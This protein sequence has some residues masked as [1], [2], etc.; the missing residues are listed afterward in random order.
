[1][2]I[3]ESQY[4]CRFWYRNPHAQTLAA[5]LLRQRPAVSMQAL[6]LP[7]PDGDQLEL[8]WSGKPG[9]RS[10][11]IVTH[12]LESHGKETALLGVAEVARELGYDALTWSMRSCS[13]AI[14][15]TRWFYNGEDYR[16][17]QHLIQHFAARYDA[18]YL[19]GFSLGGSIT[20]NYLGRE[21]GRCH[22]KVK[23]AFLIS[24]PME[25]H[26]FHRSMQSF[27]NHWLYQRRFVRSLLAKYE[28][29]REFIEFG[30]E[31]DA[32]RLRRARTVDEI[33]EYLFAP[34]HGYRNAVEYRD[35]AAAGPHLAQS[36]V[37]VYVL[38]SRDDPF[39][40]C[41][42]LPWKSAS[43]CPH[44]YLETPRHGGHMGFVPA[45][46]G[47]RHWHEQRLGHFLQ[48]LV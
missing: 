17:L 23:G 46:K 44:I 18:I 8:F 36:P 7:T 13:K 31:V 28:R 35:H 48:Q 34:L 24:P 30:P 10:L 26:S 16:D 47:E 42:Q 38:V 37:P 9:N 39:I 1:M 22:P 40:D 27:L 41:R 2:P 14:N 32:D 45:S 33:E 20:A 19:V 5:T 43:Q 15:R 25:L 29:K 21:A 12:G 6:T 4:R 11:V 3:V